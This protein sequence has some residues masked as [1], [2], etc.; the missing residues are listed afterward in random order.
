MAKIFKK[1]KI[2]YI[3]LILVLIMT[4]ISLINKLMINSE[5][6]TFDKKDNKSL[7]EL[8]MY[9]YDTKEYKAINKNYDLIFKQSDVQ[10]FFVDLGFEKDEYITYITTL[11]AK[12]LI[13]SVAV[14]GD[15][16]NDEFITI[17]KIVENL[18][19]EEE[20]FLSLEKQ[21]DTEYGMFKNF[22][23]S[24]KLKRFLECM[25]SSVEDSFDH[26]LKIEC[27]SFLIGKYA[28]LRDLEKSDEFTYKM[29]VE[30]YE[31]TLDKKGDLD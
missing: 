30:K 11:G 12:Y 4:A 9:L 7:Y 3:F 8:C 16:A 1:R 5:I 28:S 26:D 23:E 15:E 24:Y 29:N 21:I 17:F 13:S 14:D 31:S 25:S 19:I 22:F 18:S 2:I 6:K 20:F 10:E 27:Y